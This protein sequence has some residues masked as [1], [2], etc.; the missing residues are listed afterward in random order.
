MKKYIEIADNTPL[1]RASFQRD[2]FIDP[3][4]HTWIYMILSRIFTDS[5]RKFIA[6]KVLILFILLSLAGNAVAPDT[7]YLTIFE[8][9]PIR[10]YS[11][12]MSAIGMYE[13]MGNPLAFNVLENAAGIF[14]IRQVRVDDYNNRTGSN[15]A[16]TDMFDYKVSEKVFIYF[17]ELAG[18]YS[19]ERIAK[20][21]NGSGPRTDYYWAKIKTLLDNN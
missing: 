17:A 6:R 14:Q 8:T 13:T 10:P 21:W 15:Y 2:Y 11:A 18:P 3:V 20:G 5:T 4:P 7:P 16:L 12:L 9:P 19:F 1:L